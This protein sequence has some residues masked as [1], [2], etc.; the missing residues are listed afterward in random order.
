M[1]RSTIM[2]STTSITM[3][4]T[5]TTKNWTDCLAQ[6]ARGAVRQ[7]LSVVL[8]AMTTQFTKLFSFILANV[9]DPPP[10]SEQIGKPGQAPAP[11]SAAINQRNRFLHLHVIRPPQI[12]SKKPSPLGRRRP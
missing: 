2:E 5:T 1:T 11:I 8:P 3:A 9:H 12:T 6:N 4:S 7:L 10:P